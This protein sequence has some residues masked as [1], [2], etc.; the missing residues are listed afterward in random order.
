MRDHYVQCDLSGE[1]VLRSKC[2]KMWDNTIV[3]REY[4]ESRHPLDLQK[5]VRPEQ[6]ITDTRPTVESYL[7]YGDVTKDDL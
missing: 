2:V 7:S 6:Q 1:K 5:R 4:A 3:K